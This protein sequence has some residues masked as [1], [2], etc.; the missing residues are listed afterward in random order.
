MKRNV[1]QGGRVKSPHL[2]QLKSRSFNGRMV[3]DRR[4]PLPSLQCS[5]HNFLNV[6]LLTKLLLFGLQC[7][8]HSECQIMPAKKGVT[9]NP[10]NETA[11]EDEMSVDVLIE[12]VSIDGMCGVY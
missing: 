11:T 7:Q 1:V 3:S 5:T 4:S 8:Y 2:K 9:V 12:D 6:S 10:V